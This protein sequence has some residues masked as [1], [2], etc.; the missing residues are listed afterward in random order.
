MKLSK[1]LIIIISVG[2]IVGKGSQTVRISETVLP[3][4]LTYNICTKL[5]VC[6]YKVLHYMFYIAVDEN[7]LSESVFT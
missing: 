4:T 3:S 6:I 5:R 7:I 2:I 1:T